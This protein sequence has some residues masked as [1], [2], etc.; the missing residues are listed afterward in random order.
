LAPRY[1][2]RWE[3]GVDFIGDLEAFRRSFAE[4]ARLSEALGPYKLSL[5]SGSDKFSVYPIAAELARGRVHLKTAGTSYLEGLRV[6]AQAAPDLFRRIWRLA[7]SVYARDR[8]TYHV[9]GRLDQAP[10]PE[11]LADAKLPALLD[12]HHVRQILHVTFGSVIADPTLAGE[13]AETLGREAA[14]YAGALER[15]FARHLAPFARFG[16]AG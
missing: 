15:H 6:A 4:H 7:T 8:A 13:L 9:S 3:K 1:V 14:S 2:G 5:H 12:D 11:T 16:A 10:D